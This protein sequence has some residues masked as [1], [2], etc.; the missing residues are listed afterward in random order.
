MKEQFWFIFLPLQSTDFRNSNEQKVWGR[1]CGISP[2]IE[3]EWSNLHTWHEPALKIGH[4]QANFQ[5]SDGEKL[6]H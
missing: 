1:V 6:H 3:H 4:W 5:G 2:F